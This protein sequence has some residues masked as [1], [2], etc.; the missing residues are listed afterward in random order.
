MGFPG[1]HVTDCNTKNFW[2]STPGLWSKHHSV[3][4]F[5]QYLQLCVLDTGHNVK[6]ELCINME[7]FFIGV[8]FRLLFL[9]MNDVPLLK[10]HLGTVHSIYMSYGPSM[11]LC[12]SWMSCHVV[13]SVQS[14]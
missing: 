10:R 8:P 7:H 13:F 14:S 6:H 2:L 3:L 12:M 11:S 9:E 5:R 4:Y 1:P